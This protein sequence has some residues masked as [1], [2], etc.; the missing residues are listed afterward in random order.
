MIDDGKGHLKQK[1]MNIFTIKPNKTLFGL[2]I[3]KTQS[4]CLKVCGNSA[5]YI[6]AIRSSTA[7]HDPHVAPNSYAFF[8]AGIQKKSLSKCQ[9]F[10]I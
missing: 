9:I 6:W 2:L 7:N 3:V 10:S 5:V 1:K 8:S 4:V